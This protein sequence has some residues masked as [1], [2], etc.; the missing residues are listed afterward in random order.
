[1]SLK[2]FKISEFSTSTFDAQFKILAESMK[3]SLILARVLDPIL[4]L[5]LVLNSHGFL[6][7]PNRNVRPL[8][9]YSGSRLTTPDWDN[10]DF[11]NAL[12]GTPEQREAANLKYKQQSEA[13]RKLQ[14]RMADWKTDRSEKN[15]NNRLHDVLRPKEKQTASAPTAKKA[16]EQEKPVSGGTRFQMMM[17]MAKKKKEENSINP[18][19]H[20]NDEGLMP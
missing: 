12:S 16:L 7:H 14:E 10:D 1:M 11:L 18:F 3:K 8:S 13:K 6:L 9:L 5:A 15:K 17:E 4:L 2:G 20:L 19:S